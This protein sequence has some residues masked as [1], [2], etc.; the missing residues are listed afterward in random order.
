MFDTTPSDRERLSPAISA[1]IQRYLRNQEDGNLQHNMAARPESWTPIGE[2]DDD[3][4][5]A[6]S[7]RRC[8]VSESQVGPEAD[9]QTNTPG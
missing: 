8:S 3:L 2:P 5:T 9:A 7:R 4:T 1:N 6:I